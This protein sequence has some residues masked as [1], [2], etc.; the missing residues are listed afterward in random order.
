[1]ITILSK[2]FIS[3][4]DEKDRRGAYGILCSIVG[5]CLNF[6]LFVIK[7]IAGY[8]SGSVAI[9]ADAFNNLSDAGSSFV[10]LLGFW[11]AGRDPDAEHP[12]G[13]GRYEYI[14]G[15]I[16][17]IAILLM[18]FELLKSSVL[19]IFHPVDV[20]TG[21]FSFIA[22]I[23]SI[24]VKIYMT[25]Y[26]NHIGKKINS[27]AMLAVA[28]DSLSDVAAT[29]IVLLS[30]I[31]LRYTGVN[32]DG[33]GGVIVA[34]FIMYAGYEAARDTIDP[35][36]G[37][38]PDPEFVKQVED[39]VMS[40]EMI[41]GIH[42][43]IVHDY[44][45]DQRMISLHAEVP[46]DKNMFE[47]HDLIDHVEHELKEVLNCESVIHMDP[48]RIDDEKA[49]V[50]RA[51]VLRK[52][53]YEMDERISIHDFR[54]AE[55]EGHNNLMFDVVVPY[56]VKLKEKEIRRRIEEIVSEITNK[57]LEIDDTEC[58]DMKYRAVVDVDRCEV[59]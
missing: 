34:F 27:S 54:M 9:T 51:Y 53:K 22:L 52:I 55:C 14:A 21:W 8:I 28:R 23:I 41:L 32:L 17:S 3:R 24:L 11:F 30:V 7:F 48:V 59:R 19:K 15:F 40:H 29:F 31:I 46:G 39:I 13:H 1:M 49:D 42:D 4:K 2:I 38:P 58:E 37:L 45:P 56:D 47:V 6:F 33:Y 16:V 20:D 44:G 43:L 35:L 36:L 50:V 26:N 10:A 25:F 57:D 12:F 5:I 18:G